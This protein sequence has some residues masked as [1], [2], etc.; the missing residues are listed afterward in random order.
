[1]RGRALPKLSYSADLA[2]T[3]GSPFLIAGWSFNRVAGRAR[4]SSPA[5]DTSSAC[6]SLQRQYS[7]IEDTPLC[8]SNDIHVD[9]GD[10]REFALGE[11]EAQP[12]AAY[13][14]SQGLQQ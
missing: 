9:A 5:T 8:A 2:E 11:F 12:T 3:L 13:L 1:M 6:D 14:G 4:F 10:R 7:G